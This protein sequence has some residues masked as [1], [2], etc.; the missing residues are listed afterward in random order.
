M[1]DTLNEYTRW[2]WIAGFSSKMYHVG[3]AGFDDPAPKVCVQFGGKT[4]EYFPRD[5]EQGASEE[6][7]DS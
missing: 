3:L 7:T 2:G 4:V 1:D 5:V 6:E